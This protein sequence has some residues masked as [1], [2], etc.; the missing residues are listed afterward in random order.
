MGEWEREVENL[1]E[2]VKCTEQYRAYVREKEKVNRFPELKEQI[3]S[4]RLRNFEIQNMSNDEELFFK[5]EEF[6]RE[7]E[8]F[9]ENPIVADFLA[10]ELSL[11]RLIQKINTRITEALNFE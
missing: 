7:Y 3:D 10:A 5:M 1:I 9:R 6:E 2:T 8:K 4:Y 11:C